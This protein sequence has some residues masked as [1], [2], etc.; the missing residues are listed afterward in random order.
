MA[1]ALGIDAAEFKCLYV[2]RK[3]G[4]LSLRERSNYDCCFLRRGRCL[5]YSAR[6]SQCRTFP[7]WPDIL[8]SEAAWERFAA[9]CP[10]MNDGFFHDRR[11]IEAYLG[12]Y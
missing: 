9:S 5:I 4:K 7:F 10:G 8:S 6:P 11:E 3:Y 2:W 1:G 12:K